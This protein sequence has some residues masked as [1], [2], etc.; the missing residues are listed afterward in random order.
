MTVGPFQALDDS[1]VGLVRMA[2]GMV[3]VTH[4]LSSSLDNSD[5]H[6]IPPGGIES[7]PMRYTFAE[8]FLRKHIQ[9]NLLDD[10]SVYV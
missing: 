2:V 3:V 6:C 1:F 7:K 9:K 4:G 10:W 5:R 8:V